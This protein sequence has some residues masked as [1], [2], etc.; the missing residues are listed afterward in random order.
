MAVFPSFKLTKKGEELLN[1]SIGE[2]KVL[3]FTKFEI[4]DGNPPSDFREQTSLVNKFY[5]FPVLSTDIQKNQVLRI[6]GYFDNKSFT[7][8]KQLKEIGVFVKI[9][10]D[11]TEY[12]YSY[13]NAGESGDIIPGN[14]RGFYS[15]TLDVANY[16]GY[17]T[18]ITFNIEQLRDRYAFNSENEMKVAS[19]LKEGDKVELWGNLVLGDKPV[20]EYIV[21]STGEVKLS[22]GLY[23]KK[24]SFKYTVGTI[25][26]MKKLALKVGDVVEVLGYYQ[27]GD[28]SGHKRKIEAADDGS[29]VQLDNSKWAN[30]IHNGEVNLSWFGA[31]GDG[32]TDDTEAIKKSLN[33]NSVIFQDKVYIV[34]DNIENNIVS[35]ISAKSKAV[36][37]IAKDKFVKF[38]S[39]DNLSLINSSLDITEVNEYRIKTSNNDILEVGKVYGV[40]KNE[41]SSLSYWRSYYKDGDLF[42]VIGKENGYVILDKVLKLRNKNFKGLEL[43]E[44]KRT[45]GIN[46][47]N[48]SFEFEKSETLASSLRI[49][50]IYSIN[51]SNV[52]IYNCYH[53]CL[54]ID[55]CKNVNINNCYINAEYDTQNGYQYG[56]LLANSQ[57]AIIN[58]CF[59]KHKRHA[60]DGGGDDIK[61][62]PVRNVV[63][64]NCTLTADSM[65]HC[66]STHGNC[67]NWEYHHNDIYGGIVIRGSNIRYIN[68]NVWSNARIIIDTSEL[69]AMNILL[70][71][72]TFISD[73]IND[74]GTKSAGWFINLQSLNDEAFK[75][76][77]FEYGDFII[78]GN[79][80]KITNLLDDN[81]NASKS[82]I[83]ISNSSYFNKDINF[84]IS[85]NEIELS[86]PNRIDKYVSEYFVSVS[87]DQAGTPHCNFLLKNNYI[88][89]FGAITTTDNLV[90]NISISNNTFEDVYSAVSQVSKGNSFY[91]CNNIVKRTGAYIA[92]LIGEY[93]AVISNNVIEDAFIFHPEGTSSSSNSLEIALINKTGNTFINNNIIYRNSEN[94]F[95][96]TR[97]LGVVN[98]DVTLGSNMCGSLEILRPDEAKSITVNNSSS[99]GFSSIKYPDKLI[100][101]SYYY[102]TTKKQPVFEK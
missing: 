4:G 21:Q 17:A 76:N 84:I 3:T 47:K 6:K 70:Q 51:I 88:K 100:T 65:Y 55:K 62:F 26:E 20:D 81:G 44:F 32:V 89:G 23:A 25:E 30:I 57:D 83:Y 46:I 13:T 85:E 35:N 15:R 11:E 93:E 27:S 101:G 67:E 18:N 79:K 10:N 77:F 43:Y 73:V 28:G 80:I 96:G 60:T 92:Q 99:L 72:N 66:A 1:R 90:K 102:D 37:K 33:Y 75:N 95:S 19:Y 42:K 59:I 22:N 53:A 71:G 41:N 24:V 14:T 68:N 34:T 78:K 82:G 39:I 61:S 69:I 2:G 63:V 58:H 86:F 98:S 97:W 31:K 16:I 54:I 64:S 29:G 49:S 8:D 56:I 91:F 40:L 7:G 36:L 74:L 12:L 38:G 50:G 52:E 48:V 5:Q 45:S 9:E 87:G 94:E